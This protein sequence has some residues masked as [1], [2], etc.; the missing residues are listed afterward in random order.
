MEAFLLTRKARIGLLILALCAVTASEASLSYYQEMANGVSPALM[1]DDQSLWMGDHPAQSALPIPVDPYGQPYQSQTQPAYP[2]NASAKKKRSA[3][4][5]TTMLQL[6]FMLVA[7]CVAVARVPRL[8]SKIQKLADEMRRVEHEQSVAAAQAQA[9]AQFQKIV[10]GPHPKPEKSSDDQKKPSQKS[11]EPVG[12][13]GVQTCGKD[14]PVC[15]EELS[16]LV[17]KVDLFLACFVPVRA[18]RMQR[19]ADEMCVRTV[20][21]RVADG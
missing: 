1:E 13:H 9:Q 12:V 15:Y 16:S 18:P 7:V 5:T 6:A 20:C 8:E 4:S 21:W 3:I 10:Y 14:I 19:R 2:G 17:M 11:G